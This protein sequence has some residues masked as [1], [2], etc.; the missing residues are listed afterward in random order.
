MDRERAAKEAGYKSNLAV[1]ACR[2]LDNPKIQAALAEIGTKFDQ[3]MLS[4]ELLIQQ[5]FRFITFDP[6]ELEDEDGFLKVSMRS[7]PPEVRQC[8]AGFDRETE[9]YYD[10]DGTEHV[11]VKVKIR[12]IDKLKAVEHAMKWRQMLVPNSTNVN[13]QNNVTFDW[14]KFYEN[15]PN[16]IEQRM[17]GA[18]KNEAQ[19]T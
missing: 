11:K 10:E 5:L 13:I 2:L 16:V 1:Q 9:T 3:S 17:K 4:C 18:L 19:G 14:S 6:A 12:W 15:P 7:I 8:I